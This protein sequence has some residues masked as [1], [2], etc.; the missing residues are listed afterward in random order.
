M[1]PFTFQLRTTIHY[2]EGRSEH[3]FKDVEHL[4][5]SDTVVLVTDATL[6]KL[7]L[8]DPIVQDLSQY[9]KDVY[10]YDGIAGEP[11]TTHID[12][13]ASLLIEKESTLV[14]GVGGGSA[15]D[16]AKTAALVASGEHGAATYA[17]GAHP[18]PDKRVYCVG[19]PTTAGTGA[20]V[21]STTIYADEDGRKLWAW[22]EQMAPELA[23]LD[24]L[25]TT[26]LPAQLT[27]ATSIDAIVHAIEACTGQNENP[28]IEAVSL[29]AIS[30]L[31]RSL[32]VALHQP[33]DEKAR[34]E[35][36]MGSTLA[37]VA[38][39]HGGT[40]LAHCIGHAL[41][42]VA[43]IPHGR[44]VAIGLY[45]SYEHNLSSGKT[46][47][48]SE[49]ARALGVH[50]D[51]LTEEERAAAGATAFRSLVESTPISLTVEEDGL[52]E[53]DFDTLRT[54]LEAEENAPMKKNNC[55]LPS[56][57][58]LTSITRQILVASPIVG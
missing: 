13:V 55:Y 48:F 24:P 14:I 8:I 16:T 26:Q 44:S 2:G 35:L 45:H 4:A 36:L 23:I 50:G 31:A 9:G 54:S 41:G 34:G 40:G 46:A 18:F 1:N 6:R 21:T 3:L 5:A 30:M 52:T 42:S 53:D 56:E 49:I 57:E 20:E 29:Q 39:E 33:E 37:G 25:L 17:L 58:E 19:V 38:I 28:M 11:K 32:P 27:A 10:V 51:S 7:G 43:S 15:I 47:V 22:D 12:E